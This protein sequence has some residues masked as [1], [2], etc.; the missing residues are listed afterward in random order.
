[1]EYQN[2]VSGGEKVTKEEQ[3]EIIALFGKYSFKGETRTLHDT[4]SGS[5]TEETTLITKEDA[6]KAVNEVGNN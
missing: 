6:V 4:V 2:Y 5:G 1:M 3:D